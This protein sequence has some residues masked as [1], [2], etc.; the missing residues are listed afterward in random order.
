MKFI[1]VLICVLLQTSLS[2]GQE[3]PRP[4]AIDDIL[5]C[6]KQKHYLV[7]T[8]NLD[9]ANSRRMGDVLGRRPNPILSIQSAH[10]AD[11][12]EE[13]QIILAQEI[14]LGGKLSALRKK[15]ELIH[16]VKLNELAA[17]QEDVVRE[18]L[19]NIHHLIHLKETLNVTS[20]VRESLSK[21]IL[22][23]KRRPVLT[24]EQEASLINFVIQK[25]EVDTQIALL[26]D[27]EKQVLLFFVINSG[28]SRETIL[29]V[30]ENHTHSLELVTN[31]EKGSLNLE[32]LML[33]TKIAQQ[34][35]AL[36]KGISWEGI[37]FGPM[38]MEDASGE[39]A[40]RLFGAQ[41]TLPLPIWQRNDA[42]RAQAKTILDSSL[43]Q[44]SFIKAKEDAEKESVKDRISGLKLLL[45]DL[46]SRPSLLKSHKR[47]QGLYSK[48]LVSPASFLEANRAL[49]D[50]TATRLE[51]EEKILL[52]QIEYHHLNGRLNEVH[53]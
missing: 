35:L 22:A 25:A 12:A 20:E 49:R 1:L 48:G 15:G 51:L 8:R 44:F 50:L 42:G 30:M 46:P 23:L 40:N 3:C 17:T 53:I 19:L 18:V 32:K 31:R 21:V 52:L 38:Y 7:R 9:A 28:Y 43:N 41:L 14:D 10:G 11:G 5:T 24:P 39:S 26:Q 16:K 4:S 36:Q 2:F 13:T 34:E 37:Y 45:N 6:I 33:K 27:E 47:M 29:S